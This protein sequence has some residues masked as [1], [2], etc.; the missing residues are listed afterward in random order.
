MS[1][2]PVIRVRDLEKRYRVWTHAPPTNLKER[3]R[4][5][6][7]SLRARAHLGER[8]QFRK[9]VWALRGVS[10][11][12]R[13][14]EVF[15]VIGPNGAGKSTLLTI[16][17]R[18]TEPS[19]GRA[20]IQGRVS[21]LLEVGTG[22]HPEL[23]GRDNVF[24]NGAIL[25]MSRAETKKKFDEIVEFS[26]V[27]DFMDIPVKR[28]SSGMQVRLAFAVAAHLD[29]EVL[30]LDEVLAVGDA[31]F[32]AKC[33][34][35]I[36]EISRSGRTVLFVS[37]D[38]GSV[39]RLCENAI[40]LREGRIAYSGPAEVAVEQYLLRD[41]DGSEGELRRYR[42]PHSPVGIGRVEIRSG[43]IR[44]GEG[45]AMIRT[46]APLEIA[47]EID[48]R[49][50]TRLREVRL[51]LAIYHATGA[52][53]VA[54][55]TDIDGGENVAAETITGRASLVCALDGLPLKPGAYTVGATLYRHGE[56]VDQVD[57]AADLTLVPGP[58]FASGSVPSNYP[59]PVLVRHTWA[60]TEPTSS[61]ADGHPGVATSAA[62]R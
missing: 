4:I 46:G 25:G 22:F 50:P 61:G 55:S 53:Y 16:L 47:V 5:T 23:S 12:V 7:A 31:A 32:Q 58:F 27:R 57:R 62:G 33:H 56:L 51:D 49:R 14:G 3:V 18:I 30:L 36:D 21:S 34:A 60:L 39:A 41:Q 2:E 38:V 24:L 52:Q 59:A 45:T 54:L 6:G 44:S 8:T 35:R 29:P 28:Y 13:R 1:S 11:D 40:V 19:A 10:F 17:S 42:N 15:G 37:H 26:G 43:E 48:A 9:E 20:E